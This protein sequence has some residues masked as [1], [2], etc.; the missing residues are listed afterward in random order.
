MVDVDR[1]RFEVTLP[2]GTA[3][4]TCR[5]CGASEREPFRPEVVLEAWARE[6]VCGTTKD[7][8]PAGEG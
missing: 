1:D 2:G 4:V 6:H 8:R 3:T 5:Q 7:A